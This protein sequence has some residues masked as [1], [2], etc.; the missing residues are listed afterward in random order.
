[1]K[2]RSIANKQAFHVSSPQAEARLFCDASGGEIGSLDFGE[3][4]LPRHPSDRQLDDSGAHAL[5]AMLGRYGP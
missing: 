5:S 1:M 3:D 4:P 2:G